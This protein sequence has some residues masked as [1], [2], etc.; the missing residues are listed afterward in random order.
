M[1]VSK[2]VLALVLGFAF[3]GAM[4]SVIGLLYVELGQANSDLRTT[5]ADLQQTVTDLEQTTAA[6]ETAKEANANLTREHTAL[7]RVKEEQDDALVAYEE[8]RKQL[9]GELTATRQSLAESYTE[10]E[11]GNVEI[12]KGN[13]EI[14][15]LDSE[16]AKANTTI[17]E[18]DTSSQ[19]L[20]QNYNELVAANG[21]IDEIANEARRLRTEIAQLERERKPLIL[22]RGTA[23]RAGF[24][25]TGSMEP[26][27]TCLDEAT[28]LTD[29]D[30]AD[31]VVGATI[32]YAPA[33]WGDP[34]GVAHRVVD[35][36][37]RDGIHYFWTKGDA[38]L[39]ADGCWVP[40][41]DVEGY[42]VK[43]HKNVAME[44]AYLREQ[45]NN[46]RTAFLNAAAL[47]AERYDTYCGS[48]D[49]ST[50]STWL[51][52]SQMNELAQLW[53]LRKRA[54][55]HYNCWYTNAEEMEY[56][57]HIAYSC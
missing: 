1:Y 56:D 9:D 16:L 11:K 36:V 54:Y 20:Q 52:R 3:V 21:T 57:G 45:V 12:E 28:W 41:N 33:C 7:Q 2:K 37:T 50:C 39:E 27:I 29:F 26:K 43:I 30:P 25:C 47:Y 53:D 8:Q 42:I 49:P 19:R 17:I 40:E 13:S 35:V 55:D 32:A 46:A 22:G 31:I 4:L 10:I 18:L 48:A 34:D 5:K 38:N 6:L 15:R 23:E 14:R 24:L 44:N 51:Y